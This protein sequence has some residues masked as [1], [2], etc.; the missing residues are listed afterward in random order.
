MNKISNLNCLNGA[1][2]SGKSFRVQQMID[3]AKHM[4]I[5]CIKYDFS[6]PCEEDTFWERY[7][8]HIVTPE[9]IIIIDEFMLTSVDISEWLELF[10]LYS[11]SKFYIAGLTRSFTGEEWQPFADLVYYANTVTTLAKACKKH[12]TMLATYNLRNAGHSRLIEL[13]KKYY[14]SGC[15]YCFND[16]MHD[17]KLIRE[18]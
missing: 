10:D 11:T 15:V 4:G 9:D 12:P 2:G 1:M 17:G 14:Y 6:I 16:D 5:S 8:Q 18:V 3:T 7:N 13:D